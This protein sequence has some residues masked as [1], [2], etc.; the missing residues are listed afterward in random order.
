MNWVT[1]EK[2]VNTYDLSFPRHRKNILLLPKC[3]VIGTQQ[4]V[5]ASKKKP[6]VTICLVYGVD[7]VVFR[8]PR[9]KRRDIPLGDVTASL[10]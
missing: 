9:E 5:A 3:Q 1:F 4:T 6:F 8:C 10:I 2:S 7:A